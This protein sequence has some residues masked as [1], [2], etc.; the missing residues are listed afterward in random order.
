MFNKKHT[1]IIL[2]S[3]L[4]ISVL[5]S[6]KGNS[7]LIKQT[8]KVKDI[9]VAES[10]DDL[11]RQS[12]EIFLEP[13]TVVL[14]VNGREITDSDIKTK[15]LFTNNRAKN[16]LAKIDAESADEEQ[17]ATERENYKYIT[18]DEAIKLCIEDK[19]QLCEAENR[20]ITTS[21]EDARQT[22]VD[23]YNNTKEFAESGDSEAVLAMSQV[24]EY[25]QITGQTLDE[26]FDNSAEAVVDVG[27]ISRLRAQYIQD[28]PLEKQPNA[29]EE[30]Q[31]FVDELVKKAKI[32]W[33]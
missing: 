18:K 4:A 30:Y 32:E 33:K 29:N 13:K 14:T 12:A 25:L 2:A 1:A 28:L 27:T 3:L 11:F 6:C 21:K 20:G 26:Y 9:T 19:V 15:F 23:G 31:N 24:D 7:D 16:G 8:Q 17:K 10:Y 22:A 5:S